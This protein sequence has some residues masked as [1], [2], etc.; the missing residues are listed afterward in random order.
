VVST[1][2]SA[3]IGGTVRAEHAPYAKS[4]MEA[5]TAP[6]WE[7]VIRRINAPRAPPLPHPHNG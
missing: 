2:R 7:I 1:H 5:G 6:H 3:S 4:S